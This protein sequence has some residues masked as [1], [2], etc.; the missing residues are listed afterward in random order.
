MTK[1]AKPQPHCTLSD[2]P[3]DCGRSRRTFHR[4]V[5]SAVVVALF[6][7]WAT[8]QPRGEDD[9]AA[10]LAIV[11]ADEARRVAVFE[12]ASRAVVCIFGDRVRSGGGSG[13]VI[14]EQGYGLTN[15]H[16]VASFLESRQGFGGLADG[17]LYPLTVLGIDPGGDIAMFK[18]SGKPR[19][20]FAPLADSDALR[21]GQWVAAMG[22]PFLLAEDFTPTITL[23]IISGLHRYQEGQGATGSLLEYADC[24][25]VSTSINPGNSGGPLFDMRGRVIGING[26]ASFEQRGRVN[27]GLGY[28][29]SINQVKRF[30]PG[31]RAGRLTEHGT[32]GATVQLAGHD[33]IVNAIQALSPAE[34]AGVKLGDELCYV[35]GR[36]VRT[37]NEFN[38][39][40]ATLPADWPVRLVLRRSEQ[41]VALH[42]RLE[43]LPVALQ[44]PFIPDMAVNHA[45]I[46]RQFERF[47][48]TCGPAPRAGWSMVEWRGRL[49]S[50][51]E[52]EEPAAGIEVQQHASGLIYVTRGG[53][54]VSFQIGAEPPAIGADAVIP[55]WRDPRFWYEWHH[56][57]AP[58]FAAPELDFDWEMLVA[59][60]AE[61]RIVSVVERR[62]PSG[63]RI[64]WKF[65]AETD[66][67]VEIVLGNRPKRE[68]AK[69]TLEE[70]RSTNGCSCWPHVWRRTSTHGTVEVRIDAIERIDLAGQGDRERDA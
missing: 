65:D 12:R 53:T 25:Q 42:A 61:G 18:L 36:R 45:A 29:V 17:K 6:T 41:W 56:L 32:L 10:A 64:R 55:F 54:V 52:T 44:Q 63:A 58:L 27:V 60:E 22:N 23:G 8:A 21:V 51:Q 9:Y 38:N 39:I 69:W 15:F 47:R 70:S 43:R 19:F 14:D 26:R 35:A 16:V 34:Q 1:T 24:I 66:A 2:R 4:C 50:S 46:E 57:T 28:A 13:V 40:L 3:N 68:T 5:A 48:G 37:P 30:M 11:R 33:L 31:L 7:V 20:D 49:S 67:L 59:D 62:L